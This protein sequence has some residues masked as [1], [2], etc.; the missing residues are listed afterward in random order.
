MN[1]RHL[2]TSGAAVL[3]LALV[4]TGCGGGDDKKSADGGGGPAAEAKVKENLK[5]IK[6]KDGK[7]FC[8]TLEDAY[9]VTFQ[10]QISTFT[11]DQN[12]KD[13]PAAMNKALGLA[14]AS[15]P[16][17]ESEPLSGQDIDKID[18]KSSVVQKDGKYTATV[19]GP[20]G[21][22]SYDLVVEDGEWLI[23]KAEAG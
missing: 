23:T 6:A 22:A 4:G 15:G 21:L 3:A 1:P 7:A 14:G 10:T 8:N 17:F 16:K 5:A 2:M 19:K 20:K 12:I 9:Q 18:L 11:Q 13:C